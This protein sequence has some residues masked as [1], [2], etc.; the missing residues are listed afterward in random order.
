[1][2]YTSFSTTVKLLNNIFVTHASSRGL[3]KWDGTFGFVFDRLQKVVTDASACGQ[4][5]KVGVV[6]FELDR[7]KPTLRLVKKNA[8]THASA[9]DQK[10]KVGVLSFVHNS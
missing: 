7:L 3:E 10:N 2:F 4:K 1:M 5:N 9:C 8:V 6:G